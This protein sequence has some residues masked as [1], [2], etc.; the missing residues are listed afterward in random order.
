MALSLFKTKEP[1]SAVPPA[2]AALHAHLDVDQG[3]VHRS[4]ASTRAFG[5][6]MTTLLR[7]PQ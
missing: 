7:P 2:L 3:I 1:V 6:L 5:S 4:S